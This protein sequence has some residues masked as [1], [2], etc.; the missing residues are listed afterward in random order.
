MMLVSITSKSAPMATATATA[1]LF[2]PGRCDGETATSPFKVRN[3][4]S[5][6]ACSASI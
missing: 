3:P 6:A 2:T 1:H 5:R 4:G